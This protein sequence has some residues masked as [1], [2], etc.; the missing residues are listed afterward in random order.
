MELVW[1]L[2]IG[3]VSGWLAGQLWKGSG[4]GLIGNIIAGII[5]GFVGG[6]I[7]GKLGIGGGGLLWQILVSA[8]GAWVVLF[9]VSLVKKA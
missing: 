6:W 3:A 7:A 8:G 9:L 4:F 2:V 1:F 5:G